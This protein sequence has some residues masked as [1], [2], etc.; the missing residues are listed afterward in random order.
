[1]GRPSVAGL[2]ATFPWRGARATYA[3]PTHHWYREGLG[4]GDPA[5]EAAP[6]PMP[7]WTCQ[8]G[9]ATATLCANQPAHWSSGPGGQQAGSPNITVLGRRSQRSALQ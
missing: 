2:E 3:L 7:A 9:G 1:M 5:W 4:E 6:A 8:L